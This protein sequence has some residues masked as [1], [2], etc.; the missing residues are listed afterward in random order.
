[1]GNETHVVLMKCFQVMFSDAMFPP[2][3]PQPRFTVK[4][5]PVVQPPAFDLVVACPT[6]TRTVLVRSASSMTRSSRLV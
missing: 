2:Q 4:G 6:A 1:M 3:V 5:I